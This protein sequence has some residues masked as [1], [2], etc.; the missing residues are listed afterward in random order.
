MIGPVVPP[1][2]GF[3]LTKRNGLLVQATE[4]IKLKPPDALEKA[5]HR[6]QHTYGSVYMDSRKLKLT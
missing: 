2:T 5:R 1:Y 3:L 6:R 4:N